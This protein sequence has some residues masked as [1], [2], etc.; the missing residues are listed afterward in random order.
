MYSVVLL[1]SSS[2]T[3]CADQLKVSKNIQEE[4]A[5]HQVPTSVYLKTKKE[6]LTLGHM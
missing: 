2:L 4:T 3:F 1:V 5:V 6:G